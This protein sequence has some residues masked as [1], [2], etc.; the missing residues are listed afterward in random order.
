VV[1]QVIILA[2][3][4]EVEI[5]LLSVLLKVFLE[6]QTPLELDL[7]M[8]L[9]VEEAQVLLEVMEVPLLLDLVVRV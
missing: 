1:E 7:F 4:T 5:H 8:D 3:L 9:V 2:S 6:E